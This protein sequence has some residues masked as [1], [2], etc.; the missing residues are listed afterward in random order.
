M[1]VWCGTRLVG[2]VSYTVLSREAREVACRASEESDRVESWS[3]AVFPERVR[4]TTLHTGWDGEPARGKLLMGSLAQLLAV[5]AGCAGRDRGA[6][7]AKRLLPRCPPI[8]EPGCGV[9]PALTA[10]A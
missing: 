3:A 2:I 5:Q 8:L 7:L 10:P 9:T 1:N 4:P 6:R